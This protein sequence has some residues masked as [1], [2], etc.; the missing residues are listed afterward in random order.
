MLFYSLCSETKWLLYITYPNTTMNVNETLVIIDDAMI[1]VAKS[2][3]Y[4]KGC[5]DRKLHDSDIMRDAINELTAINVR[6]I[7]I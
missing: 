5:E 1:N 7:F 6:N 2:E 4:R 3:G